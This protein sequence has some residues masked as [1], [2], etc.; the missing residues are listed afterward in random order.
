[1]YFKN[2]SIGDII[3]KASRILEA[4]GVEEYEHD[5]F[6]LSEHV[7]GIDRQRY[8][9][10]TDFMPPQDK[11]DRYFRL[12]EMRAGRKPLQYIVGRCEFMGLEFG[13]CGDVLI[14]RQDTEILAECA[15]DAIKK[16]RADREI[17]VLDMC[18]GSGCIGISIAKF[19]GAKVTCVD[20][21][22]RAVECA[23]E[24]ARRLE[25]SGVT[26]VKSDLFTDISGS[27]DLIVSNPPYIKSS[28]I[29]GLMPEVRDYE[30]ALALDGSSDGLKF[31]RNIT[32]S[33]VGH[34]N[35]GGVL[36][37]EIGCDQAADVAQ[38]LK[39][40]NFTDITIIKDLAGLDRVVRAGK[41]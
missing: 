10:D 24:N 33:A 31:Y 19:T 23:R 13:V 34:L 17:K 6:L 38:I 39:D 20:I 22:E 32:D 26:F 36:M 8:Y 16:M 30:P 3:N 7:F 21:S 35:D 1:M 40:N 15:V 18:A 12:V 28:D 9:M 11:T 4:A 2:N 41:E 27:Y 14:P 37:Y 29:A 5:S 25:V